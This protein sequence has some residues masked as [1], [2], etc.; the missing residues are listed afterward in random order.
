MDDSEASP[1][2]TAAHGTDTVAH[3]GARR[4]KGGGATMGFGSEASPC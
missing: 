2:L 3:H 1:D 4:S